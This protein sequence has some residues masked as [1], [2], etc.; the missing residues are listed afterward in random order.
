MKKTDFNTFQEKVLASSDN[1]CV[2]A[3]A[4]TGKTRVLVEYIVRFLE[5]NNEGYNLSN[6]LALTFSEKAAAE[7]R[8]R[9]LKSLRD[10]HKE[11]EGDKNKNRFWSAEIR[12]LGQAEIGTIHSYALNIVRSYAWSLGLPLGLEVE[13]NSNLVEADLS[14]C[15]S[16]LLGQRDKDLLSLLEVMRFSG[17][18]PSLKAWL[19]VM[20]TRMSSWGLAELIPAES[21]LELLPLAEAYLSKLLEFQEYLFSLNG[22][23]LKDADRKVLDSLGDFVPLASTII[24]RLKSNPPALREPWADFWDFSS[25]CNDF[26]KSFRRAKGAKRSDYKTELEYM[27]TLLAQ[28]ESDRISVPLKES[29]ARLSKKLSPM[30]QE[31]R[32]SRGSIDFDDMLSMARQIFR[33]RKDKR[34]EE[35]GRWKLLVVDEFQDTNRL[36]ADLLGLVIQDPKLDPRAFSELSFT[37]VDGTLKVF[38]D[39]NQSIYWF[40]GSE[41]A[42]MLNLKKLFSEKDAN[43]LY[44]TLVHNYRTAGPLL[45]FFNSFFKEFIGED[46]Y[47]EQIV[48]REKFYPLARP[49]TVITRESKEEIHQPDWK[50]I[51]ADFIVRY[52]KELISGKTGVKVVDDNTKEFRDPATGD[53]AIL[54]LRR[55]FASCYEDALKANG[56]SCHTLEGKRTF[57]DPIALALASAYLYLAGY[58]EDKSL[59]TVLLSP[60]GPV[61]ESSLELMVNPPNAGFCNLK[62]YFTSSPPPLPSELPEE[63]KKKIAQLQRL[64]L[65]LKPLFMRFS[66][67]EIMERIVEELSLVPLIYTRQDNGERVRDLQNF[68][69][70]IKE[71]PVN[72]VASGYGPMDLILDLINSDHSTGQAEA[73]DLGEEPDQ[74]AIKMMTCH[75]SKGLEFPIVIIPEADFSTR[76]MPSSL[77]MD[78]DGTFDISFN[79]ELGQMKLESAKYQPILAKVEESEQAERRRLFYVAATRA[80]DHLVLLGKESPPDQTPGDDETDGSAKTK[81][82]AKPKGADEPKADAKPPRANTKKNWLESFY[83]I[84]LKSDLKNS[85]NF[86][87]M[88]D[89]CE[90]GPQRE[91]ITETSAEI[92]EEGNSGQLLLPRV[93]MLDPISSSTGLVTSVTKYIKLFTPKK[94][95]RSR[96]ISE[97]Q[98]EKE[99]KKLN[100]SLY[101]GQD[102]YNS[103]ET[104]RLLKE[105]VENTERVP[106][107]LKRRTSPQKLGTLFHSAM[108]LTDFSQDKEGYLEILRKSSNIYCIKPVEEDL[109]YLAGK[110]ME[111]QNSTYG[112]EVIESLK[113]SLLVWREWP[114][115]LK[116]DKDELGNSPVILTGVVDLFYT[117]ALGDGHIIDYK[118][119]KGPSEEQYLRQ[120]EL[121][122]EALRRAGFSKE[123]KKTLWYLE[124]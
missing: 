96:T 89:A 36:Q 23:D 92:K 18:Q 110:A 70:L 8:Q 86:I 77:R 69:G 54:L 67:G 79:P 28:W 109:N 88:P 37:E 31:R 11:C 119:T 68:L 122:A 75:Q 93:E 78:D 63:E 53:I 116:L 107:S 44:L 85:V 24:D 99:L 123:I 76:G 112:Q 7:M 62:E 72:N 43:G 57:A 45:N 30:L 90:E 5:N 103:P 74:K 117:N 9:L 66:P 64:F 91:R 1:L 115:W 38:G 46:D 95:E 87:S 100:S 105:E 94:D 40:R 108:E 20:L 10:K 16:D 97:G 13:S 80:K 106:E 121:Y 61:S 49:V 56:F 114:F 12:R 17:R 51:E 39:P 102:F 84:V 41:P 83:E 98:T 21:E 101:E 19:M 33:Q 14:G 120:I 22:P 65:S 29:L 118:L 25:K 55:K 48:E 3:G 104:E 4:G 82:A 50:L 34:A 26:T 42:I 27:M 47:V 73:V 60:L 32:L 113:N 15:L 81:R 124:T 2:V 59:A 35:E 58:E 111:F 6:V 71:L 52:I